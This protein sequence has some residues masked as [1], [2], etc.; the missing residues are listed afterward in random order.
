[1]VKLD[2][3]K[4]NKNIYYPSDKKVSVV[5]IPRMN[6]LMIDGKGDPNTS[7][8]YHN[9]MEA[10]FPV[11]FK[12]KFLSKKENNQDNIQREYLAIPKKYKVKVRIDIEKQEQTIQFQA[13]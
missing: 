8:E 11:S 4:K 2:F 1:M 10:L 9:A 3:K 6:F 5:D 13:F 12:T 7:K